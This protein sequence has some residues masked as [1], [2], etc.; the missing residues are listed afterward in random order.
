MTHPKIKAGQI[1]DATTK[2][3][4]QRIFI[5]RSANGELNYVGSEYQYEGLTA[6]GQIMY[7][8]YGI[9][10]KAKTELHNCEISDYRMDNH[11]DYDWFHARYKLHENALLNIPKSLLTQ[12]IK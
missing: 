5:Y 6:P 12:L 8:R 3:T 11:F 1:W 9:N 7:K 10:N 2:A 4:L